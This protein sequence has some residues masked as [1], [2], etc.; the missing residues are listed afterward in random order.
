MRKFTKFFRSLDERKS[1][2][3]WWFSKSSWS[4]N[5]CPP[6][7]PYSSELWICTNARTCSPKCVSA[8]KRYR[9]RLAFRD[10]GEEKQL[11]GKGHI[12]RQYALCQ[13]SYRWRISP[14]SDIYQPRSLRRMYLVGSQKSGGP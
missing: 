3:A 2:H 9:C 13:P 5:Q 8:W 1:T 12:S 14:P 10:V 4:P 7:L 6:C 11:G